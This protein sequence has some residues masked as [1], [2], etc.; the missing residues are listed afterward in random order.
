MARFRTRV[1]TLHPAICVVG[2]CGRGA[3]EY[4]Q[5]R[6]DTYR[7]TYLRIDE[8]ILSTGN[9]IR[10]P[11]PHGKWS[12]LQGPSYCGPRKM[13]SQC[14]SSWKRRPS[15]ERLHVHPQVESTYEPRNV[16]IELLVV[17]GRVQLTKFYQYKFP[18]ASPET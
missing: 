11:N 1:A 4:V 18:V 9:K 10:E 17:T 13:A 12:L 16:Q 15:C 6:G 8:R 14:S 2:G 7:N 3:F 5:I